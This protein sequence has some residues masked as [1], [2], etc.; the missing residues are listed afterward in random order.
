MILQA[1]HKLAEREGLMNDPDFEPKRVAWLVHV[2]A[3]GT[4][5]GITGTHEIPPG[6]QRKKKPRPI[7][8]SFLLPREKPVTSGDRAFFLFNKAEYVFG[9]DPEQKRSSEKLQQRFRLF[10]DKVKACLEETQDEG[11]HAVNCFLEDLAASRQSVNLPP[12]CAGN[13][14]FAFVYAPDVDRLV[15]NRPKVRE[16]WQRTRKGKEARGSAQ[17]TCLVF[18]CISKRY[19]SDCRHEQT[20]GSHFP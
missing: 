11:V 17:R 16:Y 6:E 18:S 13:D 19:M 2:G 10:R 3:D 1:L 15:T 7:T 5:L 14:L 9:I 20:S 12:Q 4:F 8:K